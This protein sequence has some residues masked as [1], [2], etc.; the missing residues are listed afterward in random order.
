MEFQSL[1][2]LTNLYL[3]RLD[4]LS[5]ADTEKS[6]LE[7][8]IKSSLTAFEDTIDVMGNRAFLEE[9]DQYDRLRKNILVLKEEM[10]ATAL[11]LQSRLQIIA[12]LVLTQSIRRRGKR[13]TYKFMLEEGRLKVVMDLPAVTSQVISYP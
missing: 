5:T 10:A 6:A 4:E 9:V 7:Q 3:S 12:P 8:Q 2:E 11:E 1:E 13:I